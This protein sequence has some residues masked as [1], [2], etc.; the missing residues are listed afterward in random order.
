MDE[1]LDL[2]EQFDL[3]VAD[4][5]NEFVTEAEQQGAE[6]QEIHHFLSGIFASAAAAHCGNIPRPSFPSSCSPA[7][8]CRT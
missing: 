5:C 3:Y 6:P 7:A 4:L 2:F 1:E 8:E